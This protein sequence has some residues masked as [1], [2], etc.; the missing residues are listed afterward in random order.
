MATPVTDYKLPAFIVEF[1]QRLF[2]KKPTFFKVLQIV[3]V[4]LSAVTGLP[5][6]LA[7]WGVVLPD[8]FNLLANKWVG[9]ISIV[10]A[11]TSQLATATET[12]EDP[13]KTLPLTAK[14]AAEEG[15]PIV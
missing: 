4:V 15:K 10:V 9:I 14:V 8:A 2:T 7:S 1:F 11:I 3:T 13:A 6:L 5:E 12:V